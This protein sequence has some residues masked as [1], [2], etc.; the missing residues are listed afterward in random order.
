M[1][2]GLLALGLSLITCTF[3]ACSPAV[4]SCE[5]RFADDRETAIEASSGTSCE[6]AARNLRKVCPSRVLQIEELAK[7]TYETWCQYQ[8]DHGTPL[9]PTKLARVKTCKEIDSVCR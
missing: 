2:R 4:T 1:K 5:M 9:C 3:A 6:R 8:V 7:T